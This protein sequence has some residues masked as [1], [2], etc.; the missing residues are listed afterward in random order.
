VKA[1]GVPHPIPYQ[2]SKRGLA[3]TIISYFPQ[4][5]ERLVEP[6]AGSA[7]VSLAAAYY[8]KAKRFLLNDLNKALVN[9]WDEIINKPEEIASAYR[10]LWQSQVGRERDYYDYVRIHFNKTQR[11]D[12]FLY[13]LARCVKA[14][15]RYNSYGEFNQSPDN[16]R[17]G[18]HP[19]TMRAH[20]VGASRLFR[21]K[22]SLTSVDYREALA[23][24]TPSDI[25]YMDPPYQGVCGNRDPRYIEGLAFDSFVEMLDTLNG[26]GIS[27][28]VSYDGRTGSKAFGKP[29]PKSLDLTHI[30]IDAGRSSQATLLGRDANTFEFLYLS[31]ALVARIGRVH[32]P[33]PKHH[34]YQC[35][36]FKDSDAML[37]RWMSQCRIT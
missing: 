4:D 21:G 8:G 35:P 33:Q 24:A 23:S 18:A 32:T 1:V 17:K 2:G 5:A 11:P 26:K 28:I 14:S 10:E 20:I 36:L 37:R 30:E 3:R 13:L 22:T 6:F 29:L 27:F 15:V 25:V 9:L 31:P 12:Y 34:Q 7:A 16:R 19:D